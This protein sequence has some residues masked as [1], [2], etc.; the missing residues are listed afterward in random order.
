MPKAVVQQDTLSV[1]SDDRRQPRQSAPSWRACQATRGGRWIGR[2]AGG[3][4]SKR[5]A[6]CD[7]TC[8][9]LRI[10]LT[11]GQRSEYDCAR[12]L[13]ADLPAAKQVRG[14]NEADAD[15]FRDA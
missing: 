9:P 12:L 14:E 10:A 13:L 1:A 4:H 11:A 8:R 2:T 5:D 15:W 3:L 7:G 6:V